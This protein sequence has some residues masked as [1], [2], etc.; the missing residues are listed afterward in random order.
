MN[1][2]TFGSDVS[3]AVSVCCPCPCQTAELGHCL[4]TLGLGQCLCWTA[5]LGHCPCRTGGLGQCL[6][7]TVGP[8]H[9]P[10]QTVRLGYCLCQTAR[11]GQCPCHTAGLGCSLGL[12]LPFANPHRFAPVLE[13]LQQGSRKG[14]AD[15][16]AEP[17]TGR[18]CC[19]GWHSCSPSPHL[20]P[21]C[22][23]SIIQLRLPF[24]VTFPC[25]FCS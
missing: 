11:L 7:Q 18:S 23:H 25:N 24:S 8:G 9:C 22:L 6:C 5:G 20:L 16:T 10:C 14:L 3:S 21:S 15:A 13:R 2:N 4:W 12:H 19:V 17:G 1:G